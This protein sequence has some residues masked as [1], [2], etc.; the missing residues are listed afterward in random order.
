[1]PLLISTL[2]FAKAC[3]EPIVVHVL[4][5]KGRG[6]D[7]ALKQPEKFHG[8]GPYDIQTAIPLNLNQQRSQLIKMYSARQW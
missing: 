1:L 8:T 6:Y 4:T 5:Q 7:I 3:E 2:E